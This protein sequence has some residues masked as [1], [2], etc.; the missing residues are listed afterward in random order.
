MHLSCDIV[1]QGVVVKYLSITYQKG[2]VLCTVVSICPEIFT[3][4]VVC[5]V[6]NWDGN[7]NSFWLSLL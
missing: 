4:H 7:I 1:V 6:A 2:I 3:H 5:Q